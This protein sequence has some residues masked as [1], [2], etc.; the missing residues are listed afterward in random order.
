MALLLS[1]VAFE[2]AKQWEGDGGSHQL[3]VPQLGAESSSNKW[4]ENVQID[5]LPCRE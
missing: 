5:L 4:E 2:R 1:H 3:S